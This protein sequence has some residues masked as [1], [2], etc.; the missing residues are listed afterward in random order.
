LKTTLFAFGLFLVAS[1]RVDAGTIFSQTRGTDTI[2]TDPDS[3]DLNWNFQNL[4]GWNQ[5][6]QILSVTFDLRLRDDQR[7]N[8]NDDPNEFF[9]YV[10]LTS[11]PNFRIIGDP[12]TQLPDQAGNTDYSASPLDGQTSSNGGVF[13]FSDL[14]SGQFTTRVNATQG[15]LEFRRA[16]IT[17]D[18]QMVPEPGTLVLGAG[19]LVALAWFRKKLDRKA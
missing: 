8:A 14:L 5:V 17:I 7:S 16:T 1:T 10:L 2:V 15:D 11:G 9:R 13:Q 6:S 4:P 12:N 18:A 19:A 3:L